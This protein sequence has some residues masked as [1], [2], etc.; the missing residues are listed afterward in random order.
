MTKTP[1]K[2]PAKETPKADKPKPEPK[3]QAAK[4]K[5]EV[6][7]DLNMDPRQPY[8]TKEDQP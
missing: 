1:E 5:P 2:A 7:A 8:P 3:E 6:A 4:P